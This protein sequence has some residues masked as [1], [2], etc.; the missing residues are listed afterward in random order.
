M[1]LQASSEDVLEGSNIIIPA[2]Y[3]TILRWFVSTTFHPPE[4]H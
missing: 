3:K 2:F 1:I 4:K